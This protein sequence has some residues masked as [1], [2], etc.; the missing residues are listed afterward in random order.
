MDEK[1]AA[2]SDKVGYR[3]N[4]YHYSARDVLTLQITALLSE[5][6]KNNHSTIQCRR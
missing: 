1:T 6:G 2:E 4:Q 5:I 3:T